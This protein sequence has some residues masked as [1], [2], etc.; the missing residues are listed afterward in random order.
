MLQ[1]DEIDR[2][3]RAAATDPS[4]LVRLCDMLVAA[5]QADEAVT[6]CRHELRNRPDD[7]D[8]RLALGRALSA[9]GNLE[10]AQAALSD[11]VVRKR[12]HTVRNLLTGDSWGQGQTPPPTRSETPPPSPHAHEGL[13]LGVPNPAAPVLIPTMGTSRNAFSG[14]P[15]PIPSIGT[16]RNTFTA[17]PTPIASGGTSRHAFPSRLP[18]SGPRPAEGPSGV[19][20]SIPPI[21]TSRH[22]L[23]E[24]PRGNGESPV[25]VTP[26][27]QPV[28]ASGTSPIGDMQQARKA[29]SRN[30]V[31]SDGQNTPAPGRFGSLPARPPLPP[32]RKMPPVGPPSHRTFGALPPAIPRFPHGGS[33]LPGTESELLEPPSLSDLLPPELEGEAPPTRTLKSEPAG[34]VGRSRRASAMY[35]VDPAVQ[36]AALAVIGRATRGASGL[37]MPPLPP[38]PPLPVELAEPALPLPPSQKTP[39]GEDESL[40]AVVL[41]AAADEAAGNSK[42]NRLG[43]AEAAAAQAHA[44]R[45]LDPGSGR[46]KGQPMG[47][48]P[49]PPGSAPRPMPVLI[50]AP[51]GPAARHPSPLSR[52]PFSSVDLSERHSTS[53]AEEGQGVAAE[54]QPLVLCDLDE[55]AERLLGHPHG[56]ARSERL[57]DLPVWESPAQVLFDRQRARIFTGIWIAL[58]LVSVGVLVGWATRAATTATEMHGLLRR[59]A[60]AAATA[61]Y[62]D[63]LAAKELYQ[64]ALRLSPHDAGVIALAAEVEVRLAAD[65]GEGT[66]DGAFVLLRRAEEELAQRRRADPEARRTLR[67]ASMLL[68]LARGE[69]CPR[70][71]DHDTAISRRED[72]DVAARCAWQEGDAATAQKVL[73]AADSGSAHVLLFRGALALSLGDLEEAD[74]AYRTV[75]DRIPQQ[76]RALLGRSMVRAERGQDPLPLLPQN[77][78]LG[79]TTE[80]WWYLMY[81]MK[82]LQDGSPDTAATALDRAQ[83]G[84][85][86]DARLALGVGRARLFQGRV[87]EA[88]V[89]LRMAQRRSPSDPDLLAFDAEVALAKGYEDKVAQ[90]LLPRAGDGASARLL[91]ALG[92]AQYLI[93]DYQEG[94]STLSRMLKLV[95]GDMTALSYRALCRAR[96]GEDREAFR[97]LETLASGPLPVTTPHYALAVLAYDHKDL[98]RAAAEAQRALARNPDAAR[99]RALLGRVLREQGK[100]VPAIQA[101]QQAS[102]DAPTLISPHRLLG[103]MY[104]DLSRARDARGELL[105]VVEAGEPTVEDY[106]ALD[107]ATLSLGLRHEAEQGVIE[108]RRAGATPGKMGHIMLILQTYQEPQVAL[109]AAAQ[110]EA[111]RKAN[112]RDV[113]LTLTAAAAW[114]RAGEMKSALDDYEAARGRAPMAANL[115][116]GKTQARTHCL[117]EAEAAYRAALAQW[118]KGP[119]GA[120]SLAEARTGLARVL[121]MRGAYPEAAPLLAQVLKD[122]PESAEGHLLVGRMFSELGQGQLPQAMAEARRAFELDPKSAEACVLL[123]DL[124]N[125]SRDPRGARELYQHCLSLNPNSWLSRYIHTALTLIK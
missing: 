66:E 91:S 12:R 31:G 51:S 100:Q 32:P 110:L 123:G 15:A 82:A 17:T 35:G 99:A 125:R 69:L 50:P 104:L 62:E 34:K 30:F 97:D 16:S 108:A 11:A 55:V 28:P 106:L 54:D 68:S 52:L 93:G 117:P 116:V 74:H 24:G 89:G 90:A 70:L 122:D 87:V 60:A 20:R 2:M 48:A 78:R 38:P 114:F 120:D 13:P 33:P 124:S 112:Q 107:E 105:K 1:Q 6:V 49:P 61:R 56:K 4:L 46:V 25:P 36:A 43:P 113:A 101:L 21:G 37:H 40:A 64:Q 14:V 86:H 7:V 67:R 44:A 102:R 118:D 76:A 96:L 5:G 10:E 95:P 45:V 77:A 19:P 8:L 23:P 109:A 59:A 27:P 84:W 9:A 39:E 80:A 42:M 65:H 83:A 72:G 94:L 57:Q 53:A 75:L 81:G 47:F 73:A 3:R 26:A 41:A 111:E 88:E 29:T 58:L 79:P 92:R 18:V 98:V 71:S 22:T 121:L 63:A 103:R 115:G 119:Y 85:R